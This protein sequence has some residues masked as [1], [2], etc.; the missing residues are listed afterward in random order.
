MNIP[1]TLIISTFQTRSSPKKISQILDMS[2]EK[3]T[4]LLSILLAV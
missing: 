1:K 4:N 3:K 2:H